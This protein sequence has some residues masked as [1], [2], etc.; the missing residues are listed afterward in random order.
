[1]SLFLLSKIFPESVS[2]L[3]PKEI[4][5]CHLFVH[6]TVGMNT[7]ANTLSVVRKYA[8]SVPSV[9]DRKLLKL[10]SVLK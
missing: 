4:P 8:I 2:C 3:I 9:M 5:Y 10:K 1:M 6:V 7:R